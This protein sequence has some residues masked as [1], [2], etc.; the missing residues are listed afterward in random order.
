MLHDCTDLSNPGVPSTYAST[1]ATPSAALRMHSAA[2]RPHTP[3]MNR[4]RGQQTASHEPT[5]GRRPCRQSPRPSSR[6]MCTRPSRSLPSQPLSNQS[7]SHC[8]RVSRIRRH[9][10]YSSCPR[11]GSPSS[12]RPRT[13]L[14]L[15]PSYKPLV[16]HNCRLLA[17]RTR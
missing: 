9:R 14:I 2:K 15:I 8:G 3:Q 4:G 5:D 1:T 6:P 11:P 16:R 13:I 10:H 7:C 17:I 12:R